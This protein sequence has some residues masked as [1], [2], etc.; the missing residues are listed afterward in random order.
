MERQRE[1]F[2]VKAARP[3]LCARLL[4]AELGGKPDFLDVALIQMSP[5][6]VRRGPWA[7]VPWPTGL[8]P[9]RRGKGG[10]GGLAEPQLGE[11]PGYWESTVGLRL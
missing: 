9:G 2:G 11:I 7:W 6:G 10:E 4:P 3:A 5:W 8:T 1:S